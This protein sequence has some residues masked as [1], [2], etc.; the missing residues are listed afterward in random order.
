MSTFIAEELKTK[1]I[2]TVLWRRFFF[3][4]K[5]R[6]KFKCQ[7]MNEEMLKQLMPSRIRSLF[8]QRK[9]TLD[10]EM[11]KCKFDF[12]QKEFFALVRFFSSFDKAQEAAARVIFNVIDSV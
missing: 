10:N 2:N 3:L 1:N 8:C 12:V 9:K 11:E 4:A 5:D 7:E 6:A